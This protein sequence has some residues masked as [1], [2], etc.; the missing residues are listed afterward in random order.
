MRL[1]GISVLLGIVF[2]VALYIVNL[3]GFT[4]IFPWFAQARGWIALIAHGVFGVMVT[5][6]YRSLDIRNAR[7]QSGGH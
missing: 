7:S 5:S 4:A 1:G 3:Y 2:G 6:V